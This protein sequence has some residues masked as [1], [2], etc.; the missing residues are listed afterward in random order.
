MA[1]AASTP[2]L[3]RERYEE[4]VAAGAR[5]IGRERFAALE[6]EFWGHLET[7]PYMRARLGL[8]QALRSLDRAD[9]AVDHYRALLRLNPGDNQ[10]VRYLLVVAL[11]ELGR[12]ADAGALLAEYGDDIQAVW[13][14]ARML[15][16]FR[17][18]GDTDAARAAFDD[19][20]AVNPHVVPY[21][22]ERDALPF[23]APPHFALRSPEEAAYAADSL[24]RAFEATEGA[25]AW[26]LAQVRRSGARQARSNKRTRARP[27][28]PR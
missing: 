15:W 5:A 24:S 23:T 4:A 8:A 22:L 25:A 16:T 1:D 20:E 11:L 2:E 9:E 14:Y 21:L 12:N 17:M 13:P 27:Q 10:G 6:G 19:A 18:E 3:A 7:R 28:P 26:L